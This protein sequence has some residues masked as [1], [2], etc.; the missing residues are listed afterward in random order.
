[1]TTDEN[2]A[3]AI[4]TIVAIA[5][6]IVVDVDSIEGRRVGDGNV[7]AAALAAVTAQSCARR[8]TG[9]TGS[10]AGNVDVRHC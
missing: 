8:G 5:G 10:V 3:A 2:H 4:A 1:M 9:V 7:H 6:K